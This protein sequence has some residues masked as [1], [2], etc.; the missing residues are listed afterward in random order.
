MGDFDKLPYSG[1]G[2]NTF[3]E[4]SRYAESPLLTEPSARPDG[5]VREELLSITY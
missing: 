2:S 3:V 4:H 1:P 5:P